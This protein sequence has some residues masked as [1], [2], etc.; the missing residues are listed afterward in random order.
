MV[1]RRVPQGRRQCHARQL[2]G[3]GNPS[4]R[5]KNLR[6]PLHF[7]NSIPVM[8]HN[9]KH[10]FDCARS[11]WKIENYSFNGLSNNRYQL[12]YY[13]GHGKKGL[14]NV[15]AD[16]QLHRLRLPHHL[17]RSVPTLVASPKKQATR[18]DFFTHFTVV[19][20]YDYFPSSELLLTKLVQGLSP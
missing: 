5:Q 7:V 12:E 1:R 15:T 20:K 14:T 9:V 17:R 19:P 18:R 6:V 2:D 3:T 4:W 13:F 8:C 16:A 11:R 10:L